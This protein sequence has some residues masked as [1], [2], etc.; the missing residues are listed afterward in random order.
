MIFWGTAVAL[1]CCS[2]N[3]EVCLVGLL[4]LFFL[5][6]YSGFF[7]F[8]GICLHLKIKAV[9]KT[10]CVLVCWQDDENLTKEQI[11]AEIKKIKE[12]NADDE[13]MGFQ[14]RF[15]SDSYTLCGPKCDVQILFTVSEFPDE[16]ET[17]LDVP[18][19]KRFAKYRGLKSFRTSSWDPKVRMILL[20]LV[21][22][23]LVENLCISY[24]MV[25]SILW[26]SG[27]FAT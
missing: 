9:L 17:P 12:S 20:L 6:F 27:I 14:S 23:N 21:K 3:C 4:K 8:L 1:P 15:S 25:V 16:V 10:K 11:E 2:V 19:R 13:G 24:D 22:A 5:F 7:L 26:T 18:A